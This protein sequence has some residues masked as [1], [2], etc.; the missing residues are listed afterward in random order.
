MMKFQAKIES[1]LKARREY[2]NKN[3]TVSMKKSTV[4]LLLCPGLEMALDL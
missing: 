1:F 2:S 4:F 3:L